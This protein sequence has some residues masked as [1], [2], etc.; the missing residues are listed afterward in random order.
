[1]EIFRDREDTLG[2]IRSLLGF[3]WLAAKEGD[4]EKAAMLLGAE[5][6]LRSGKMNLPFPLDWE[7]E[8]DFIVAGAR[9]EISDTA[10]DNACLKGRAMTLEEAIKICLD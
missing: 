10:F 7:D 3:S 2:I 4:W 8:K 6:T 5:D 9:E 1:M